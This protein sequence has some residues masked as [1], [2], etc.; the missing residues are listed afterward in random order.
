METRLSIRSPLFGHSVL[1]SF[2]TTLKEGRSAGSSAQQE[3]ISCTDVC[4]SF[5]C[6]VCVCV[7]CVWYESLLLYNTV[8]G[9]R[10]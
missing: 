10:Y 4:V 1:Y 6:V 5:V 3:L 9:R 2:S 7:L 8:E